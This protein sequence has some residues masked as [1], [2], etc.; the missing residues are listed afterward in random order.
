MKIDFPFVSV[1]Q[2]FRIL[3][4][5]NGLVCLIDDIGR[6]TDHVILW[7][8][9]IRRSLTLPNPNIALDYSVHRTV[10]YGFGYGGFSNDYKIVRFL[11][12]RR[13]S[14]GKPLVEIFRLSRGFWENLDWSGSLPFLDSRQAYVSGAI[15]WLAEGNLIMAFDVD[16]EVLREVKLPNALQN[17]PFECLIVAAWCKLLCVF[18][19]QYPGD[20]CLW[21]M[22]DCGMERTWTRRFVVKSFGIPRWIRSL[23]KNGEVIL[24]ENDNRLVSF[25]PKTNQVRYSGIQVQGSLRAFH[26]KSYM[27]SLVLLDRVD[28]VTI[29]QTN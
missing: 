21:V 15:H 13:N 12:P 2:F 29:L 14:R 22:E 9:V 26:M 18:E 27:E 11:S 28:G 20:F 19:S 24:V 1:N 10:V 17:S 8:P 7:N 5:V 6:R 3:G 23:R 4:C 16:P 25:D